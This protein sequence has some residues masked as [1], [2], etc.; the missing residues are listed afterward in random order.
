MLSIQDLHRTK[1][2]K[3]PKGPRASTL[4]KGAIGYLLGC[5]QISGLVALNN[6]SRGERV[7]SRRGSWRDVV[8]YRYDKNLL[9]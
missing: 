3:I 5:L 8:V 7:E 1:P 4:G 6:K 2:V 9:H